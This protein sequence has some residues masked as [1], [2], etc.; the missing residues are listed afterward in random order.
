MTALAYIFLG[1]FVATVVLAAGAVVYLRAVV[2]LD[3]RLDELEIVMLRAQ[4]QELTKHPAVRPRP[5]PEIVKFGDHVIPIRSIARLESVDEA[6]AKEA[7][8][9]A[10]ARERFEK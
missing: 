2:R 1:A 10:A 4:V 8:Q 9:H 6:I 3:E 5:K 7:A